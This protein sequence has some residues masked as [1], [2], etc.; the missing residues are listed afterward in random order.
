MVAGSASP[1]VAT[2][3]RMTAWVAGGTATFISAGQNDTGAQATSFNDNRVLQ[4]G[5]AAGDSD[6]EFAFKFTLAGCPP[7]SGSSGGCTVLL[8]WTT[9]IAAAANWGA[10]QGAGSISGSASHMTLDG[11]DQADG[12]GR[13]ALSR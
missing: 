8:G 4:N 1:L 10:G 12:T 2:D 13:A 5:S 9:H 11:V 3:K 6:R 7:V